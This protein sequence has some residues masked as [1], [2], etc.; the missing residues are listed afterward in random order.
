[1]GDKKYERMIELGAWLE[2]F[3]EK[4][5]SIYQWK[6]TLRA[7]LDLY[8]F[9]KAPEKID[10]FSSAI[11]EIVEDKGTKINDFKEIFFPKMREFQGELTNIT[12]PMEGENKNSIQKVFPEY[13]HTDA[14]HPIKQLLYYHDELFKI[15]EDVSKFNLPWQQ[16]FVEIK[17]KNMNPYILT[18]LATDYS[19]LVDYYHFDGTFKKTKAILEFSSRT[20]YP[21]IFKEWRYTDSLPT[22]V[23]RIFLDF[24]EL[25]G[26]DYYLFCQHC[27]RFTVVKR[28]GRKKFCSDLCRSNNRFKK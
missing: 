25:G 14:W 23:A 4:D 27:G 8:G 17:D 12:P 28:K 22:I 5:I 11:F 26:Q 15:L 16:T 6:E 19:Y 1:M 3:F 13:K 21:T 7:G 24:L 10:K 9:F 20:E 18:I 2:L